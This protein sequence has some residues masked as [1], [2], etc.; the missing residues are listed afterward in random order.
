[1]CCVHNHNKWTGSAMNWWNWCPSCMCL[2]Q[3]KR[4]YFQAKSQLIDFSSQFW[5]IL[6]HAIAP[7]LAL[8]T[9]VQNIPRWVPARPFA[10]V[11]RPGRLLEPA[12]PPPQ[13]YKC[14]ICRWELSTLSLYQMNRVNGTRGIACSTESTPFQSTDHLGYHNPHRRTLKSGPDLS[15]HLWGLR[16]NAWLCNVYISPIVMLLMFWKWLITCIS[17]VFTLTITHPLAWLYKICVY[18]LNIF[19][20]WWRLRDFRT[21]VREGPPMRKKHAQKVLGS[22]S[23][24]PLACT[25]TQ[26]VIKNNT[27]CSDICIHPMLLWSI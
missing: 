3:Q 4:F 2:S 6:R 25:P 5:P 16:V 21:P 23:M 15:L 20:D 7:S 22:G 14:V 11:A 26:E 10:Q 9:W 8:I 12:P 24:W 27:G 1:M 17:S 18:R 13:H 19:S